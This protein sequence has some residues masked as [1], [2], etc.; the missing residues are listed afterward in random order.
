MSD[1]SKTLTLRPALS[2][3]EEFL[4]RVYASTRRAEVEATGWSAEQQ[5]TFIRMQYEAQSQFYK[6]QYPTA[7]HDIIL[8]DG[9]PIGRLIVERL[10]SKIIGVDIALLD[11]YC[12]AGYGGLLIRNLLDE[13]RRARVPF[14]I[15]VVKWNKATHLYE[16]LGFVK[17]GE[18]ATH[19]QMEWRADAKGSLT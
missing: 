7:Q 6:T 11:E 13:A 1:D 8:L 16:R 4:L 9:I 14:S 17:T 2:S 15:Q 10:E 5:E 18:S 3:D 12:N 19:Y